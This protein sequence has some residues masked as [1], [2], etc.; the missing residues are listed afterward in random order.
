M[1]LR[2]RHFSL[3]LCLASAGCGVPASTGESQ[4]AASLGPVAGVSVCASGSG[5][6][7]VNDPNWFADA[8]LVDVNRDGILD[9]LVAEDRIRVV[10][11]RLGIG[12]GG[13][14]PATSYELPD[15]DLVTDIDVGDLNGDGNLDIAVALGYD[16]ANVQVLFG[17]G[18][19]NFTVGALLSTLDHGAGAGAGASVVLVG[20]FNGDGHA[21]LFTVNVDDNTDSIL[22]GTGAGS[23]AAARLTNGNAGNDLYAA[24]INHDG[25]LDIVGTGGVSLGHGDGTFA[26]LASFANHGLAPFVDR[27]ESFVL[28]DFNGDG[29]PDALGVV[30]KFGPSPTSSVVFLA[31]KGDGSFGAAVTVGSVN[32]EDVDIHGVSAADVDGDGQLDVVIGTE[33][34]ANVFFGAGNGLFSR[35]QT[36][37]TWTANLTLASPHHVLFFNQ[38]TDTLRTLS[39]GS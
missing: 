20:D 22:L 38:P 16:V 24:D 28:A 6:V 25:K 35:Q 31:G 21:D 14:G 7:V 10:T 37:T 9:L 2:L 12:G 23:F 11:V 17:K 27:L 4:A 33:S 19:G 34:G 29:H 26:P 1:S 8:Q 3:A 18:D 13:F 36:V 30:S 32:G 5:S 15:T 39:C